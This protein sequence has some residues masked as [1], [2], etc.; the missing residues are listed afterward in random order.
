MK[1][2]ASLFPILLLIAV[3]PGCTSYP[4]EEDIAG[5]D[6][7]GSYDQPPEPAPPQLSVQ[8]FSLSSAI[9]SRH[10]DWLSLG[11]TLQ[12]AAG[13]STAY[14][15]QGIVTAVSDGLVLAQVPVA[16][17]NMDGG[18]SASTSVQIES[19]TMPSEVDVSISWTDLYGSSY[20]AQGTADLYGALLKSAPTAISA[21]R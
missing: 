11:L 14:N 21:R 7:D 18:G 19:Y 3:L 16:L 12:N 10:G 15:V 1:S 6:Q 8:S 20:Y 9:I 4:S 5:P 13:A 17:D 2:T